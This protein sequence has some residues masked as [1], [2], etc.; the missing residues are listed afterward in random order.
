LAKQL[1]KAKR[2]LFSPHDDL[3][4]SVLLA[5]LSEVVGTSVTFSHLVRACLVIVDHS[6][7]ELFTEASKAKLTRPPNNSPADITLFERDLA[8]LIH[9]SVKKASSL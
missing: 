7:P 2:V 8:K 5:R 4:L 6:A 9:R 3:E 1:D